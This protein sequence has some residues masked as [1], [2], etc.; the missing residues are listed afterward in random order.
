M[1]LLLFSC[2]W[3]MKKAHGSFDREERRVQFGQRNCSTCGWKKLSWRERA[4]WVLSQNVDSLLRSCN[5]AHCNS[6]L[7]NAN[8]ILII[9]SFSSSSFSSSSTSPTTKNFEIIK[10]SPWSPPLKMWL[11]AQQQSDEKMTTRFSSKINYK[12]TA[13]EYHDLAFK[14][15]SH[16]K[17]LSNI[18]QFNSLWCCLWTKGGPIQARWLKRNYC[19]GQRI[20]IISDAFVLCLISFLYHILLNCAP[21][22]CFCIDL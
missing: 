17:S 21:C 8:L 13:G 4:W 20:Y 16:L 2:S 15:I 22:A 3:D 18:S 7:L 9:T 19:K 1:N 11:N 12:L 10:I 5:P 14:R 6:I